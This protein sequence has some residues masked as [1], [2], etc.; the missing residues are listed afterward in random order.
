MTA[1]LEALSVNP[2][3]Y[4]ELYNVALVNYRLGCVARDIAKKMRSFGMD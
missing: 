4:A 1:Y 2:G 3:G